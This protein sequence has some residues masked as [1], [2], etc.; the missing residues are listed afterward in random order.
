MA[1]ITDLQVQ[2]HENTDRFQYGMLFNQVT[3]AFRAL[4]GILARAWA[5]GGV[6]QVTETLD[7]S[8]GGYWSIPG[9][10]IAALEPGLSLIVRLP[11]TITL[12]ET[13][14][15]Q[16][17]T[18]SS[19]IWR[20]SSSGLIQLA[21]SSFPPG[22]T[23]VL[24]YD[25]TVNGFV[26]LYAWPESVT[27]VNPDW[28]ASSGVAAI[29]NKPI[30]PVAQ[31]QADWDTVNTEAKSYIKNKPTIPAA[32]VQ[33]DWDATTGLGAI[34]NKPDLSP[35]TFGELFPVL[36]L[37]TKVSGSPDFQW[38][39]V[40]SGYTGYPFPNSAHNIGF[41][42]P[43][44]PANFQIGFRLEFERSGQSSPDS[45]VFVPYLFDS[46]GA[47]VIDWNFRAGGKNFGIDITAETY[48]SNFVL[49]IESLSELSTGDK[50]RVRGAYLQK[51]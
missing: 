11:A 45:A 39:N 47:V 18:L 29:L 10:G 49:D 2:P 30:I 27:Y 20:A 21:A 16:V 46:T 35:A 26:A 34:L 42:I 38:S 17:G 1:E 12:T 36:G 8:G 14:A 3:P 23:T 41:G 32:Q 48:S 24:V 15:F 28:N 7:G 25:S 50:I 44:L 9:D 33:S 5:Y 19:T 51:P 13:I 22:T 40:K 37:A 4:E 6:I 31:V 43:R